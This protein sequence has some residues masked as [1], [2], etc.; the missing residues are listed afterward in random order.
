MMTDVLLNRVKP[1]T[2]FGGVFLMK[3][4]HG[5]IIRRDCLEI[6]EICLYYGQADDVLHEGNLGVNLQ[7]SCVPKSHILQHSLGILQ[8]YGALTCTGEAEEDFTRHGGV[9]L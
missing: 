8:L 9:I 1:T 7:L 3:I 6:S 2:F 5:N 4:V